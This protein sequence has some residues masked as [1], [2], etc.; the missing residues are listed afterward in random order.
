MEAAVP[1]L[2]TTVL[3]KTLTSLASDTRSDGG[4]TARRVIAVGAMLLGAIVGR[5]MFPVYS[6]LQHDLVVANRFKLL[7]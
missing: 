5:V 3:T 1:E 7:P 2:T 4:T 6:L